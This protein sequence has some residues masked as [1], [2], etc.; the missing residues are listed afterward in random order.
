M[1]E[2]RTTTVKAGT[3]LRVDLEHAPIL[4]TM[5]NLVN[6]NKIE[7]VHGMPTASC[8]LMNASTGDTQKE[9][10]LGVCVQNS[11]VIL[12]R[13]EGF[14]SAAQHGHTIVVTAVSEKKNTFFSED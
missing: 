6:G 1:I 9:I 10:T 12:G 11:S 3:D 8:F 7:W 5:R 14:N 4:V 2:I 13:L